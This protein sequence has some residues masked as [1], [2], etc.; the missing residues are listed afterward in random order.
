MATK[1][2]GKKRKV[3]KAEE[4]RTL[5]RER[6]LDTAPKD[7][8]AALAKRRIEVSP[9]QVSNVKTAMKEGKGQS[10]RGRRG[11][12]AANGMNFDALLDAKRLVDATGSA[13]AAKRAIDVLTQLR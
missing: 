6:G 2:A 9:A 10:G 8:I 12:P 5:F 13:D 11:R 4:I 3:N 1:K 7:I